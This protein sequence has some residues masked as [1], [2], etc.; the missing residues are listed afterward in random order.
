M[1]N[2]SESTKSAFESK[3]KDLKERY[4]QVLPDVAEAWVQ[5]F[6]ISE[7]LHVIGLDGKSV[8]PVVTVLRQINQQNEKLH[9]L[10]EAMALVDPFTLAKEADEK[11]KDEFIVM[12]EKVFKPVEERMA[13]IRKLLDSKAS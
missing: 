9:G 13:E 4:Q 7:P 5:L 8:L 2:N 10:F 6:S 3:L 1:E 12:L 11:E